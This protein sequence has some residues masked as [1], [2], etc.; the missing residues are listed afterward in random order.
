[1][2]SFTKDEL[3][4]LYKFIDHT[5]G[6]TIN[7]KEITCFKDLHS[8]ASGEIQ[9]ISNAISTDYIEQIVL[10]KDSYEAFGCNDC[11]LFDKII[12]FLEGMKE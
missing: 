10:L 3:E 12:Q 5:S 2:T 8:L 11:S 9:S 4:E 6:M 1:M 7:D